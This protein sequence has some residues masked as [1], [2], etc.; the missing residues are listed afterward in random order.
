MSRENSMN[1]IEIEKL[2]KSFKN[3]TAVDTIS[4]AVAEKEIFGLLGP[5]GAGKTTTMRMLA[6]LLP[7]TSG[8]AYVAG[9]DVTKN[10]ND[11]RKAIGMVFQEPSLD[12]QL[13]GRENLDFHAW[14]YNMKKDL[15]QK[16]ILEVLKLV[17]LEGRENDLVENY[18][19]GMQRRLEIARGLMHFPK[20]LFLDEPTLGLDAQTRRKIWDHIHLLNREHKTTVILTTHYMDE[21]DELCGRV[22]IM[23]KGKIVA[24]DTPKNLKN[25]IGADVVSLEM[26]SGDGAAFKELSYVQEMV[27]HENKVSLSVKNGERKIPP[28][29]EFARNR[30]ITVRSVELHKPSLEDVFLHFTGSTIQERDVKPNHGPIRRGRS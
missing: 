15:R 29:L 27:N 10:K 9:Y 20:V 8:R 16:R 17:E 22:G 6:T 13:T 14:M 25:L 26:E 30:G 23:D 19:G 11:V 2:V 1:M 4:F 18:S 28:L 7:P 21:A 5:N 24:M 3:V 12:R